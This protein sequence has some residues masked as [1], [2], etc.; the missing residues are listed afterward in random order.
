MHGRGTHI[1]VIVCQYCRSPRLSVIRKMPFFQGLQ[2]LQK[3][4]KHYFVEIIFKVNLCN[5]S[6][7]Q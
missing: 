3:G 6:M 1:A 4:Q 5:T 7:S 2:I